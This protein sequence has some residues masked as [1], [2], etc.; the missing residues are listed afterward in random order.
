MAIGGLWGGRGAPVVVATKSEE[1]VRRSSLGDQHDP[2]PK[3]PV[4]I[5]IRAYG[6]SY[7][8]LPVPF[9]K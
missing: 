4:R 6:H 7:Y 9:H 8:S 2:Y 3:L 1:R 5:Q